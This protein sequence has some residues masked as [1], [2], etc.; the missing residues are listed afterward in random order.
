MS[1]LGNLWRSTTGQL[2]ATVSGLLKSTC[3]GTQRD[4]VR[5]RL[6]RFGV[7]NN[8]FYRIVAADSRWPRDGKALEYLGTYNPHPNKHN[9]KIITIN[10]D[11]VKHWLVVGAQP[12][13]RVAKIL[14]GANILPAKLEFRQRAP[15]KAKGAE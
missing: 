12:T 2:G 14:G 4:M 9:E 7:R 3:P 11:R 15:K 6:Q 8:P 13:E 5:L 1:R 10:F